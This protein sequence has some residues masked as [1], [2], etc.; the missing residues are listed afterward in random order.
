MFGIDSEKFIILAVITALVLGPK[1]MQEYAR[2]LARWIRQLREFADNTQS[3]L[4]DELGED[5]DWR[6]LDPRQ[7][8]PRRIIREALAEPTG[9]TAAEATAAKNAARASGNSVSAAA[10]PA[11]VSLVAGEPAPFDSEAT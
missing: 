4:S 10:I 9:H 3:Q 8:D 6:Q 5:L 7:Y 11:A 1:R 2:V